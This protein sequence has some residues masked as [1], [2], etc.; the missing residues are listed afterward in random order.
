MSAIL[1]EDLEYWRTFLLRSRQGSKR[2]IAK[3][4]IDHLTACS[5]CVA[6]AIKALQTGSGTDAAAKP[7]DGTRRSEAP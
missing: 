5:M 6:E 3:V 4:H 1:L 2:A 7:S